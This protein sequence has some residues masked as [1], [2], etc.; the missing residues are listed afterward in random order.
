[1]KID[2][3]FTTTQPRIEIKG[4]YGDVPKRSERYQ[5]PAASEVQKTRFDAMKREE[6]GDIL[7]A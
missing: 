1:M 5:A 6:D 4:N 3:T 2:T 7:W